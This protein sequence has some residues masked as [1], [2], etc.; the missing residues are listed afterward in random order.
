M[1]KVYLLTQTFPVATG[2]DTFIFPELEVLKTQFEV[3]CVPLD[4]VGKTNYSGDI[5][6]INSISYG[7]FQKVWAVKKS[8]FQKRFYRQLS[9]IL[10]LRKNFIK[11]FLYTLFV[12]YKANLYSEFLDKKVF[13]KGEAAIVYSYWYNEICLAAVSLKESYPQYSFITR[14][15]GYDLFDFRA[16]AN[17]QPFKRYMDERL[18]MVVFACKAAKNYYM[19]KYNKQDSDKYITSYLGVKPQLPYSYNTKKSTINIVSCSNAIALKRIELII[20]SLALMD[21]L[22]IIWSHFGEGELLDTLKKMAEQLLSKPNITYNFYGYLDNEQYIQWIKSHDIQL[23]I[24]LSSTE[25]GVPVSLSEACS[26]GIP[27]IATSAGGIPEILTNDTGQL[28]T[29]DPT[30]QQV[31]TAITDFYN[32]SCEEKQQK[33]DNAY[34]VWQT[35]F[36][37]DANSLAF[38][39][40]L[41]KI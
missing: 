33:S 18:S 15:H 8:F 20:Q 12:C 5:K 9:D 4:V 7:F 31:K 13:I 2:E 29:K 24:T 1:K 34:K 35:K 36:N 26:F 37:A 22:Q 23:F 28:L 40:I 39:K 3:V 10:R 6:Y 14:T 38:A 16:S 21:D 19:E 17:I 27:C 30:P 41:S 11:G 32:L 25:G